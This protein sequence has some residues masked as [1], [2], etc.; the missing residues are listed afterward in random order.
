MENR[1]VE[2]E[3]EEDPTSFHG[4]LIYK[5]VLQET[6]FEFEGEG[7]GRVFYSREQTVMILVIKNK[8]N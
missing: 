4:G 2:E 7:G 6:G 1:Q 5:T 3:E 8:S